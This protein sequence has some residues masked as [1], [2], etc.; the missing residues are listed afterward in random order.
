MKLDAEYANVGD[1]VGCG[2]TMNEIVL[3]NVMFSCPLSRS[4][5]AEE[6]R[7]EMYLAVGLTVGAGVTS[8]VT[9]MTGNIPIMQ[10]TLSG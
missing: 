3:V 8:T 2:S 4:N 6:I 7:G 5:F 1:G 10:P 9:F